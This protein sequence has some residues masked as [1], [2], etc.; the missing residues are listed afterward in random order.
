M[1]KIIK[2]ISIFLCLLVIAMTL[3]HF[4]L[5]L[6]VGMDE[7]GEATGLG[8]EDPRIIVANIIRMIFGFLGIIAVCLILYAGWLYMTA[9]GEEDK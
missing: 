2:K 4:V 1:L 6:D 7:I 9:G 8:Q 3:A 5:A